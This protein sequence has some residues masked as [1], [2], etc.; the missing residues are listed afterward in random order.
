MV[1]GIPVFFAAGKYGPALIG[2][3]AVVFALTTIATYIVLCVSS[4][5]GLQRVK[6]GPLER[7]G[8]V[9]SGTF[10][11]VVGLVFLVFPILQH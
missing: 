8:E 5:A 11:V 2:V 7:Y 4:V 6:L 10:I 1:E 3:M 9:L